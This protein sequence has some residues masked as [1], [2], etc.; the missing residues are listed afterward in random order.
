MTQQ[1]LTKNQQFELEHLEAS[2]SSNE[3][4][5]EDA[6]RCGLK[7][8]VLY[9]AK[10]RLRRLG[11]V[12]DVAGEPPRRFVRVRGSE[13]VAARH[14]CRVQFPN[15]MSVEL[16]NHPMNGTAS[17]NVTVCRFSSSSKLG[18]TDCGPKSCRNRSS[19][20]RF[21]TSTISGRHWCATATTGATGWTTT[22]SR[23]PSAPFVSARRTGSSPIPSVAR[24]PVPI[25]I[26]SST[27]PTQTGSN[28]TP[29][30]AT[31]PPGCPRP[32]RLKISRRCC[33]T[34]PR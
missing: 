24:R 31:S 28:P 32:Y 8:K 34:I 2:A 7:L 10:G 6:E 16:M 9:V 15:G 27:P 14:A 5:K 23:M 17:A 26:L 22:A 20:M 30:C 21:N 18:R 3:S 25:C 12:D 19:A 1:A 13:E 4:L 11:V 29:I 33:L